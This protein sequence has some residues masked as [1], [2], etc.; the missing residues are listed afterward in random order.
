MTQSKEKYM[1]KKRNKIEVIAFAIDS[2][3]KNAIRELAR[4]S[5][6][7]FAAQCRRMLK[8]VLADRNLCA[9]I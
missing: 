9:A 1:K 4:N 8:R 5:D 3:D 2:D 7:T 6:R